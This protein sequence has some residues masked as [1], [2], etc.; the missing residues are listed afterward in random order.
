M[1]EGGERERA[2]KRKK[3][4]KQ[5]TNENKKREKNV[6]YSRSPVDYRIHSSFSF[7]FY[8]FTF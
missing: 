8:T 2:G 5:R 1:G 6:F 4:K 7:S 3:L